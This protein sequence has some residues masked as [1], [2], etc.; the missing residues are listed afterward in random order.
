MWSLCLTSSD[1]SGLWHITQICL[2]PRAQLIP[3]DVAPNS[4]LVSLAINNMLTV[5]TLSPSL[6]YWPNSCFLLH[7]LT[8]AG[9]YVTYPAQEMLAPLNMTSPCGHVPAGSEL[10]CAQ[11]V[12]SVILILSHQ[13]HPIFFFLLVLVSIFPISA[14]LLFKQECA[15]CGSADRVCVMFLLSSS[16]KTKEG[17]GGGKTTSLPLSLMHPSSAPSSGLDLPPFSHLYRVC[18]DRM[19]YT[20]S[21]SDCKTAPPI[22]LHLGFAFFTKNIPGRAHVNPLES[23]YS[24]RISSLESA[25]K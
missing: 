25:E 13:T 7:S 3:F 4:T 10:N 15:I 20:V 5:T 17:Q 18:G 21:V 19:C 11:N 12:C 16:A 2:H 1:M 22:R 14:S 6:A 23:W 8:T 24:A 9:K